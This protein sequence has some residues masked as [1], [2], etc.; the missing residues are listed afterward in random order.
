MA[1]ESGLDGVPRGTRAKG[2]SQRGCGSPTTALGV[3]PSDLGDRLGED[4]IVGLPISESLSWVEP[5]NST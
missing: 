5:T 3:G 4:A 2:A 1:V